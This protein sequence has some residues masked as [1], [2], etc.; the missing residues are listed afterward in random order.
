MEN[1]AI[2]GAGGLGRE[3][4]LLIQQINEVHH[5]WNVIGFFDDNVK[6]GERIDGLPVLGGANEINALE[7]TAVVMAIA[8]PAL[9]KIA[10]NK[11]SNRKI[12]FPSIAH[13]QSNLGSA[14][15]RFGKGSIITAGCYLTTGIDIGEFVIVNLSCTL[16]HDVT[17]GNFTAVMP[18]CNISGNVKV[19]E[20]TLIGTGAKILQNITL[21]SHCKVGAGAVITRDF[22]GGQTIV[23]VPAYAKAT[24]HA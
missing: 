16:G 24:T 14:S 7:Q 4:A 11:I 12:S 6:A 15:N 23:G 22:E 1:L 18:G 3:V 8:E 17:L 19:G 10:F 21:G 13:P 2:Y 5:R 20:G 9:R